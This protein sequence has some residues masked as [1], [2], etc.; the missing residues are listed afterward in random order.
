MDYRRLN[1]ITIK[2]SY[3]LPNIGKIQDQLLGARWLTVLN[4]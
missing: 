3:P 2:D 1:K 4:L